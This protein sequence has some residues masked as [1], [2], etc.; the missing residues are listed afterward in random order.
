MQ[1][2]GKGAAL[3]SKRECQG[4]LTLGAVARVVSTGPALW[5]A[6]TDRA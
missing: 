5:D 3:K 4:Y 2:I 1:A 6:A